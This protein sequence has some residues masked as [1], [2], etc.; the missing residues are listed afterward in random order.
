LIWAFFGSNK[1]YMTLQEMRDK[2]INIA[3]KRFDTIE[4]AAKAL[5]ITSRTL[6]TYLKNKKTKEK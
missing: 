6:Y 3:L 5:G 1:N 4:E 2:H